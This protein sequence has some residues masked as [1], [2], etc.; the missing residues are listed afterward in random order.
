MTTLFGWRDKPAPKI[1]LPLPQGMPLH[2]VLVAFL[3]YGGFTEQTATVL[4]QKF[5]E[6]NAELGMTPMATVYPDKRLF[7][8][9]FL[10]HE[11]VRGKLESFED[12]ATIAEHRAI[13]CGARMARACVTVEKVLET[14]QNVTDELY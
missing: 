6:S 1:E 14:L 8:E 7:P 10:T 12:R 2:D 13:Q 5:I 3:R 9:Q 11:N 4:S